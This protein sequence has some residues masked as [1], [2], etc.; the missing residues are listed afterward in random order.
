MKP[1]RKII[2]TATIL[3][4]I[5]LIP[6]MMATETPSDGADRIL[7]SIIE[8]RES[9][10]FI[11]FDAYPEKRESLPIGV[12]D[13]GTGGLT[14]LKAIVNSDL[15]DNQ[16]HGSGSD[17]KKDFSRE[18]FIYLADQANMPYGNYAKEG[19]TPLLQEHIIKDVQFLLSD[20]YYPDEEARFPRTGKSPVK[21]IVIACNTATAYGKEQVEQFIERAGVGMAVIGVIDAGVRGALSPLK[22]DEDAIIGVFATAGT[23]ASNGYRDAILRLKEEQG[24]SGKIEVFSQGGTG[25]AEAIDRDTDYYVEGRKQPITDYK[26]PPLEMED[27]IQKSLM[28]V[29]NFAFEDGKILCDSDAVED[30]TVFQLNDPVNYL[31]FHLVSLLEQVRIADTGNKLKTIILGCTHYP[32]LND[33]IGEVLAELYAYQ[34]ENGHYRYRRHMSDSITL[35]D[36]AENT[37]RELY[38]HLH[39]DSLLNPSGDLLASEFYISVPNR[40]NPDAVIDSL[41]RFPYDYKYGRN[42]G[43]IQEYVKVV[44]FNDAN[45]DRQTYDRL[46]EQTPF[47]YVLIESFRNR[48]EEPALPVGAEW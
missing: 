26:G 45:I 13:S 34:E 30:C 25:L 47:V 29:Y 17:G 44:P 2:F 21:A 18:S 39:Q 27:G 37:A 22:K 15:F 14:V 40:D 24:F 33:E 20:T 5:C 3:P 43:E 1:V 4:F 6:G 41:G 28:E 10:Y 23:V 36:P 12:F 11:D 48:V 19:K 38:E 35:I 8:D 9:F 46:R 31:R 16:D 32:F 7:S 42:A